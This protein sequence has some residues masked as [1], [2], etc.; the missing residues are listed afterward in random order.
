MEDWD[1]EMYVNSAECLLS[2]IMNFDREESFRIISSNIEFQ[3]SIFDF[4][5]RGPPFETCRR[6]LGIAIY[7]FDIGK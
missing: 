6:D 3:T 2:L 5:N 7:F 4:V 1:R